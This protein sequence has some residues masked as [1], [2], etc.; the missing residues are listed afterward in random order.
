MSLYY[1]MAQLPSLDALPDNAPLPITEESFYELC[2]RLLNKKAFA[3]LSELTLVPNRNVE[4][5]G[6]SLVD[7][8]NDGERQLRFALASLRAGT[9]N[10]T[11]ETGENSLPS[12]MVQIAK[13]ACEM[14]DPMDAERFLNKHRL[15]FLES[16]RPMDAFCDNAV[17]YYALKIKLLKRIRSFD[18]DKGREAY[19]NIYNSV[20]AGDRKEAI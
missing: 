17:F 5:S 4:N 10:K 12:N 11:F 20:L 18:E 16:L 7:Q 13:N 15:Q 6:F 1:L 9:M 14:T 2:E 8:W 19:K 3:A